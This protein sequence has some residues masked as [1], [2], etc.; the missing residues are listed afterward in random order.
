MYFRINLTK[1]V[2]NC[3]FIWNLEINPD[4]GGNMK[5]STKGRYGLKAIMDIAEYS[6][7]E[8]VCIKHISERQNISERYLE[9]LMRKLRKAGLVKS[10][11]GA[12]GGYMLAKEPSEISVGDIIRA[13]EGDLKAVH[14]GG[15]DPDNTCGNA[16]LCAARYVWDRINNAIEAAVDTVYLS[17]LVDK[18]LELKELYK[19]QK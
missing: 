12:N 19:E 11:R 14:C 17:E 4:K 9:Q 8:A 1:T 13:T 6:A 2:G 5:L 18:S 15:D 16:D 10:V 7:D 3:N